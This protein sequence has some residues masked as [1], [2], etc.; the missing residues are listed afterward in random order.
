MRFLKGRRA[1]AAGTVALAL[2]IGGVASASTQPG[3]FSLGSVFSSSGGSF[4][5]FGSILTGGPRSPDI[6]NE[7]PGGGGATAGCSILNYAA[8]SGCSG[9][10]SSIF[11]EVF[12]VVSQELGLPGE[13]VEVI[14]GK[15]SINDL[16]GQLLE[17]ILGTIG[18]EGGEV[19]GTQGYPVYDDLLSILLGQGAP[20]EV[21]SSPQTPTLPNAQTPSGV[22]PGDRGQAPSVVTPNVNAALI[23][24]V[25]AMDA[26]TEAVTSRGL[27]REGQEITLA[28]NKAGQTVTSTSA[29]MGEISAMAAQAQVAVATSMDTTIR[30]QTST[31]STLKEALSGMNMLQA[32][33]SELTAYAN[34][35]RALSNQLDGMSLQVDQE[36]RDGIFSNGKSLQLLNEQLLQDAQKEL[37]AQSSLRFEF[38][39]GVRS[40]GVMR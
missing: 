31:Q 20:S 25:Q 2:G 11:D 33:A 12:N 29:E 32:Q 37:A 14:T 9:S 3:G 17:D 8:G 7:I 23:R 18:V 36:M 1:V 40:F 22:T 4:Y 35:Q 21:T 34:R 16:L 19:T 15:R 5:D 38:A 28:R 13:L 30:G 6:W 27:T 26:L 39:T 24:P 10:R